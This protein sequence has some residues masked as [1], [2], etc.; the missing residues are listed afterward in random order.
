M[1]ELATVPDALVTPRLRAFIIHHSSFIILFLIT[2][3]AGVLRFGYLDRPAIWGDE[4]MVFMRVCGSFQQLV[5]ELQ[6]TGHAPLHYLLYWCIGKLMLLTPT[7]MRF[8]PA[9]TGTLMVPAIYALAVQIVSRRTALLAALFTACSAYMLNY[10]RDAKM[11]ADFW[12][13][14]TLSTAC[15][16]WWLRTRSRFVWYLW[17]ITGLATMGLHVEGPMVLAIQ[18]V[19]FLSHG[20]ALRNWKPPVFFLAGLVLMATPWVIYYTQFNKYVDRVEQRGFRASGINW[21][22]PYNAGRDGGDLVRYTATAFLYNWEWPRPVS[23]PFIRERTLKLLKGAGE[24]LFGLIGIG[25][26]SWRSRRCAPGDA[27]PQP[28]WRSLFWIS[29]WLILPT[30]GTYCASLKAPLPPW[31]W[32]E[33]LA[34]VARQHPPIA[35][36][37]GGWIV[38]LFVLYARTLGG[39]I[40]RCTVFLAVACALLGLCCVLFI[41]IPPQPDS[42]WMPRYLGTIWPAFAIAVAVLLMRLPTRPLRWGAIS[43]LMAVNLIQHGARVFAGSEP[44]TELIARDVLASQPTASDTRMYYRL[45]HRGGGAP[46]SGLLDSVPGRYYLAVLSG[47]SV[48]PRLVRSGLERTFRIWNLFMPMEIFIPNDVGQNPQLKRL[49]VWDRLS[50]GQIDQTDALAEK[51]PAGWKRVGEELYPVRDHWIWQ[52]IATARR[53]VYER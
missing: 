41:S 17:V 43:L 3:F 14:A 1:T 49:I 21:V 42:V 48:E 44:P 39:G 19:L 18:V 22:G 23:E 2:L 9:M 38:A 11:Y 29:A 12:L 31:E 51:L 4:A 35:V 46:G 26:F 25:I 28:W 53:R 7:V 40:G 6:I 50:P 36:L 30:Y 16:F 45:F 24:I 27:L 32:F 8:V 47:R 33:G 37:I 5:D 13:F 34:M 52:D 10:S 20:Q 15:L